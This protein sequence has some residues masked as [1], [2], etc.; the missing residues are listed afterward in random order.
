MSILLEQCR[1]NRDEWQKYS[2][3]KK[4]SKKYGE[5]DGNEKERYALLIE[6]QYNFQEEDTPLLR[7][8][9]EQEV[10]ARE[11]DDFQGKY[12]RQREYVGP[13]PT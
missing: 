10:I 7:F 1:A 8:L 5:Y 2:Y 11:E 12:R 9:L 3:N 6:L 4:I 13:K